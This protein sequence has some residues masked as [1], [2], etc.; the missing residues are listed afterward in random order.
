MVQ[1]TASPSRYIQ[2]KGLFK[3]LTSYICKLGTHPILLV[4]Q[5]VAAFVMP[6][7]QEAFQDVA[8]PCEIMEFCGEC[9]MTTIHDVCAYIEHCGGDVLLGIGGGKALDTAKAAAHI[10]KKPLIILPTVAS[11]DAPCSSLSVI[12]QEDGTLDQYLYLDKS[13]DMVLVDS[14]IICHAPAR[15]LAAGMGDALSTYF[16]ARACMQS[17]AKNS[18]GKRPAYAAL[19]LAK[20]CHDTLFTYGTTA[21]QDVREAYCSTAVEAVIEANIYMSGIGF[22]SGGMAA[23][24]AIAYAFST[25]PSSRRYMHGEAVALGTIAQLMLEYRNTPTASVLEE[26]QAVKAFCQRIGLPCTLSDLGIVQPS[27]QELSAIAE[28][29][30]HAD[31]TMSHMPF[32][33]TVKDVIAVLRELD[34]DMKQDFFIF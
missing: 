31:R 2:G 18:F 14:E 21:L 13:P 33:V 10:S 7:V 34:R 24:H 15:F 19:A 4:D 6:S 1:M 11:S 16:E 32:D 27:M 22:E 12:Y 25:V 8:M 30:C 28:A 23:A 26:L 3:Q 5:G 17:H 29:A 9:C 20:A